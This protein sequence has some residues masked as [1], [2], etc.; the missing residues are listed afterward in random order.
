MRVDTSQLYDILRNYALEYARLKAHQEVWEHLWEI[1]HN[2]SVGRQ[3]DDY[4]R[5]IKEA[6]ERFNTLMVVCELQ[7]DEEKE[8]YE[9]AN[10]RLDRHETLRL[11]AY[12]LRDMD[13]AEEFF[14][15]AY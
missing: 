6:K 10:Y 3:C 5:N 13:Y 14:N 1:G 2:E 12:W 15:N 9:I 11:L 8:I 4:E 7:K